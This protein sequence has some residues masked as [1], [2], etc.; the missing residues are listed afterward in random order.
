V[1]GSHGSADQAADHGAQGRGVERLLQAEVDHLLQEL[2]RGGGEGAAGQEDHALRLVAHQR[3]EPGVELHARQPR[4]HQVAEDDVEP[5][6]ARDQVQGL[7]GA[8]AGEDLVLAAQQP[9]DAGADGGLVV[10]HQDPAAAPLDLQGLR[11]ERRGGRVR[12]GR[13]GHAHDRPA[14]DRRLDRDLAAEGGDDAP[15]DGEPEPGPDAH[16]L[17]GEEGVEDPVDRLRRDA[18]AGVVHLDDRAPLGV[19]P[20]H[21]PDLV[22]LDVALR[23]RL[24]GVDQQVE[25]DLPEPGLAG[26]HGRG[27]AEVLH[28]AR[29]VLDLVEHHVGARL[30]DRAQ[31]H[32]LLPLLVGAREGLEVAHHVLHANGPLARL[33]QRLAQL[34]EVAAPGAGAEPP[35]LLLGEVERSEHVGQRVVDLVGHAG[36]HG[37]DRHHPIGQDQLGRDPVTVGAGPD[38]R[39]AEGQVVDQVAQEAH[40]VRVEGVHAV[41]VDDQHAQRLAPGHQRQGRH[42][43]VAAPE[44]LIAPGGEARIGLD[45][46]HHHRGPRPDGDAAGAPAPRRVAPDRLDLGQVAVL[47]AGVGRGPHRAALVVVGQ[48]DPAHPVA[49]ELDEDPARRVEQRL[50]LAGPHQRLAERAQGVEGALVAAGDVGQGLVGRLQLHA[51]VL[52]QPG[53]ADRADDGGV[54]LEQVGAGGHRGGRRDRLHH[55]GE[56]VVRDPERHDLHVVREPADADEQAEGQDHRAEGDP[57]PPDQARERHRDDHVRGPDEPVAHHVQPDQAGAPHVALSVWHVL[58][59]EED[60]AEELEHGI[61]RVAQ[62]RRPGASHIPPALR[63]HPA[64]RRRAGDGAPAGRAFG[65]APGRD[66]VRYPGHHPRVHHRSSPLLLAALVA[67]AAAAPAPA[68][69]RGNRAWRDPSP[70]A[71]G[72]IELRALPPE[73]R[74]TIALVRRGGPFPYRRDGVVFENRERRLPAQPRGH[75][76]E[77][78]VPTSGSPDRGPRRIVAGADGALYWSPDHYRSFRRVEGVP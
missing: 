27:G 1:G 37:S 24:R 47:V 76:R 15:A 45:V 9:L 33:R 61:P 26:Q 44:G 5:L 55:P 2:A 54:G 28:Q 23:D 34:L 41:G 59:G 39:D 75:Y 11:R 49:A 60:P 73:A 72:T 31:V 10:E 14:A 40:L 38:R 70:G 46:A 74:Q 77:Y 69:A 19:A 3:Q 63:G 43:G 8:P 58:V 56:P 29:A 62:R 52:G 22:P 20:A 30:Q 48:P 32:A 17:G 21:Q 25:E 66:S 18:G 7:L 64:R 65:R 35:H 71:I 12:R 6:A 57:D 68:A 16:R 78:T 51:P 4:H 36:G 67:L 50:L 42:R 53:L 13:Q